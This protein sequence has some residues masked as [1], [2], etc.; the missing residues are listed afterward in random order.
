MSLLL[1]LLVKNKLPCTWLGMFITLHVSSGSR[2]RRTFARRIWAMHI[3]RT[4]MGMLFTPYL[5]LW[6]WQ[7]SLHVKKK[8][9][10]CGR[11]KRFHCSSYKLWQSPLAYIPP[12][13]FCSSNIHTYFVFWIRPL[14][15]VLEG[16]RRR[17]LADH[18]R[19]LLSKQLLFAASL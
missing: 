12:T 9:V 7:L 5:I 8:F 16:Q 14:S 18:L 17:N 4:N 15:K 6:W 3:N 1:S 10:P 19:R 13:Y 2:I 11:S